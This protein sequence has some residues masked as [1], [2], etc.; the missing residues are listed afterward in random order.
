MNAS[1]DY[2][3]YI[4]LVRRHLPQVG[5]APLSGGSVLEDL[6]LDSLG[7]VRLLAE[8]ED[9]FGKELPEEA[10]HESTF[11]TVDSLWEAFQLFAAPVAD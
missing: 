6:G 5:E 3:A 9:T 10:L 8:L 7:T 1:S 2:A 4:A 11:Q